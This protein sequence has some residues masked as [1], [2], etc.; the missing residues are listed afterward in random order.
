MLAHSL[1]RS[2]LARSFRCVAVACVLPLLAGCRA[3]DQH[4]G[5]DPDSSAGRPLAIL[6]VHADGTREWR[7][8][9]P[10]GEVVGLA[11]SGIPALRAIAMA[12]LDGD[13]DE[14][15]N[16]LGDS[17]PTYKH[18]IVLCY[19]GPSGIPTLHRCLGGKWVDTQ[20]ECDPEGQHD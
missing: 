17:P 10:D 2:M 9:R 5:P 1:R 15:A 6:T 14:C 4:A 3:D 16:P 7:Y 12:S 18:G 20:I 8:R 11:E 13:A 19:A